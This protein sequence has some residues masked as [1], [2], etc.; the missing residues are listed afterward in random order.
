MSGF[1]PERTLA[2]RQSLFPVSGKSGYSDAPILWE[3]TLSPSEAR[4]SWPDAIHD[5]LDKQS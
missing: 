5:E 3:M 1:D 4:D 2:L